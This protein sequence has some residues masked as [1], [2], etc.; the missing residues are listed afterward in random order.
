MFPP[1]MTHAAFRRVSTVA[2]TAPTTDKQLKNLHICWKKG[3]IKR[4][5]KIKLFLD[6]PWQQTAQTAAPD[7]RTDASHCLLR[8]RAWHFVCRT[9]CCLLC[10]T[11]S[12]TL[13][14]CQLC[15]QP[16]QTGVTLR[17][18]PVQAE[19]FRQEELSAFFRKYFITLPT[20]TNRIG[21]QVES[22]QIKTA[23]L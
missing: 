3:L 19:R 11:F 17:K 8:C 16:D 13:N 15:D 6:E 14:C 5:R 18:S 9:L 10:Q 2:H 22:G 4:A 12:C 21:R 1:T 23:L 20:G 7:T